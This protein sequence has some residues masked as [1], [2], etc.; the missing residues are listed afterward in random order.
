[1]DPGQTA[2]EFL[3]SRRAR[4][5]PSDVGL[6]A[7]PGWR[8]VPGLRRD[9]V[10]ALAGVS[11]EYY[12]RLERG[13]IGGASDAVRDA[14]AVALRLDEA[15]RQHLHDL[16]RSASRPG[17]GG[18]GRRRPARVSASLQRVL[19]TLGAPGYVRDGRLEVVAANPLA[20]ALHA[21]VYDFAAETG[22]PV[23]LARFAFLSPGASSFYPD[24]DRVTRSCVAALRGALGRDPDDR[25]LLALV[26]ELASRSSRFTELWA[27]H[28]VHLHRT[29]VKRLRHPDVG[30]LALDFDVLHL[31]AEPDLT[32]VL[33]SAAPGTPAAAGLALLAESVT[34]EREH[35][36]PPPGR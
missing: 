31:A 28:D 15:E 8:R 21:P 7:T 23:S 27:T 6:A 4:L 36:E 5:A 22:A 13:A 34:A 18:R 20:R 17:R 16:A 25:E 14:V 19:D 1:M 24:R 11:A 35:A 29:G 33:Y 32:L 26:H 9:E 3:M 12:A 10:A 2:G 30:V